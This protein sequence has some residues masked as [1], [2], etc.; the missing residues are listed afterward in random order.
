MS[1]GSRVGKQKAVNISQ[2]VQYS[3]LLLAQVRTGIAAFI[4]VMDK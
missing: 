4:G 2:Y 3:F 1:E